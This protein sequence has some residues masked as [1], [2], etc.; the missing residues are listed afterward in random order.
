MVDMWSLGVILYVMLCG[1]PPF[2]GDSHKEILAAVQKGLYTL[3]HPPFRLCS[4][5]VKDLISKLIHKEPLK[6]ITAVDA[7]DHPWV[8][9]QIEEES[10]NL[11]IDPSVF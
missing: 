9:Q 3:S 2:Y 7:F 11:V 8:K 4:L 1:K 6:R 5:E 10:R